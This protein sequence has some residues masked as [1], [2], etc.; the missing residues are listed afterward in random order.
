MIVH[1]DV[2]WKFFLEILANYLS[3]CTCSMLILNVLTLEIMAFCVMICFVNTLTSLCIQCFQSARLTELNK[4]YSFL[5]IFQNLVYYFICK[6][7]VFQSWR[8]NSPKQKLKKEKKNQNLFDFF[9]Y[10]PFQIKL[11]PKMHF[12]CWYLVLHLFT[13]TTT[14]YVNFVLLFFSPLTLII[15][16]FVTS[17]PRSAYN[18]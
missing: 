14:C 2:G 8:R 16:S 4:I 11:I 1:K 7:W 6:W 15:L 17:P 9:Y 3:P 18:L 10:H 12:C 5:D 13:L